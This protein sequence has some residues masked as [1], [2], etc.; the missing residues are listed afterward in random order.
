MSAVGTY[1]YGSSI[2]V[3]KH[4]CALH[5][6]GSIRIVQLAAAP[7]PAADRKFRSCI[8]WGPAPFTALPVAAHGAVLVNKHAY[9]L[10]FTGSIR[11]SSWHRPHGQQPIASLGPAYFRSSKGASAIHGSACGC[12]WGR[13]PC[14]RT[15]WGPTTG[16]N[17]VSLTCIGVAPEASITSCQ[18][19]ALPWG[20]RCVAQA[21]AFTASSPGMQRSALRAASA[22]AG[23]C[24]G[25]SASRHGFAWLCPLHT[26]S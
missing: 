1:I 23:T 25:S 22:S 15:A 8:I 10:Q 18:C 14:F 9:A 19:L 13:T 11:N 5:F 26:P 24:R 7:R 16:G 21:A 12:T 4:A 3:N 6:T 2:V 17:M 20:H